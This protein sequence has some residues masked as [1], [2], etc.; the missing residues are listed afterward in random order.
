LEAMERKRDTPTTRQHL[1]PDNPEAEQRTWRN[2]PDAVGL[3]LAWIYD[4]PD[5]RLKLHSNLAV[6]LQPT[7]HS[8]ERITHSQ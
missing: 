7:T 5:S 4:L 1:R 2:L 8:R 6:N 3:Q